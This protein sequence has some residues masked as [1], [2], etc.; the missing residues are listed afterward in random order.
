M[1]K[2]G[3]IFL[4]IL[5]V[6]FLFWLAIEIFASAI[7]R[8]SIKDQLAYYSTD[9]INIGSINVQ[10]F[11]L[12][13][14]INDASFDLQL[15]LDTMLVRWRGTLGKAEVKGVNWLDIL[16]GG[17]WHIHSVE[18]AKGNI[19][20]NVTQISTADTN[21]FKSGNETHSN[22]DVYFDKILVDDM[23][24]SLSRDSF[25]IRLNTSLSVNNLNLV[26]KDSLRWTLKRFILHSEKG[27]FKNLV[28]DYDLDYDR[29]H[30][31]SEDSLLQIDNFKMNPRM[32]PQEFSKKYK[33]IKVYNKIEIKKI[34]LT[35]INHQ[36]A[37]RGLFA[38]E[39]LI[40]GIT[41][42]IYKDSRKPWSPGRKPMPSEMLLK[43]P[44]PIALDSIKIRN[45]NFTF[46]EKKRDDTKPGL[47]TGQNMNITIYPFTNIGY[48]KSV[49]MDMDARFQLMKAADIQLHAHFYPEKPSHNFRVT[50]SIARTEINVF[51]PILKPVAGL[52]I[53]SGI[54]KGA[55]LDMSGDDYVCSGKLDIS[56]ENLKLAIPPNGKEKN[57]LGKSAQVVGNLVLINT[58]NKSGNGKGQIYYDRDVKRPFLNYWW[59]SIETG[60]KDSMIR[61]YKSKDKT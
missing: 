42:N 50:G 2:A 57:L 31:D 19:H 7:I 20:W 61:F 59:K 52:Y 8:R 14:Q 26:R 55:T 33:Y 3:R 15:P 46:H 22:K 21:R 18:I 36:L 37:N 38:H 45:G 29:L 25:A 35:G 10:Y 6:I 1:K 24:F 58:N 49:K 41:M 44:V 56:Y 28:E 54:C 39:L 5:G 9:S 27:S 43:I 12:G 17:N 13:L 60:L 11:P 48:K 32:G 23:D 51:N 30:F 40:N 34:R 4:L 53:K 16:R 47:L